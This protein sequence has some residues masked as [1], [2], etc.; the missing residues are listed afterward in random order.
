MIIIVRRLLFFIALIG[1][2]EIIYRVDL[3]Q[4][5]MFPSPLLSFVELYRGFF[6]TG[7]LTAALTTS[8]GRISLGFALAVI[9][10]SLLGIILA[11]SKLAD[12][13]LGSLVVALQSV[14]SIVWLPLALVMFQGGPL[15]ILFVIVLGGT[16]PMTMNM[17][18]GI[19]NVQPLLIRAARTMGYKGVEL[20]WK[21][22]IPASIPSALT[23]VRLAWAFGWRALMAAELLGR[24]GLGRTL[25]DARDF[26]N[27]ELVIAIMI[28]IAV[29][30]L[31]VEYLIFN[32]IERKVL[33]R[34]GYSK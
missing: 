23:G 11:T 24:G 13:T 18:M 28:I 31:I 17:R 7:I 16:W 14:P 34:W 21:V 1:I 10:G 25:L 8:L 4:T 3:F 20:I 19:K 12:E 29:I 32:P 22:L 6:E 30:G 2:W 9:I 33:Q 27:M 15:A 5:R 26:F